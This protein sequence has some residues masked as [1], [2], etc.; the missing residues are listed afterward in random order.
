MAGW[1]VGWLVIGWRAAAQSLYDT[2]G[3]MGGWLIVGW[4]VVGGWLEGSVTIALPHGWL[5]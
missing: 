4:L 1:L 2:G 5:R 3:W